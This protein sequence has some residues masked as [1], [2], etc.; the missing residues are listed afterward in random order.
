MKLP[1]EAPKQAYLCLR[2]GWLLL[3]LE[4]DKLDG[5]EVDGQ[6]CI[7]DRGGQITLIP[8]LCAKQFVQTGQ[9]ANVE[10]IETDVSTD[11]HRPHQHPLKISRYGIAI[12]VR[13]VRY[14]A[15]MYASTRDVENIFS[16]SFRLAPRSPLAS[17][18]PHRSS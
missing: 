9:Q 2:C 7:V 3:A 4:S 14:M 13:S 10:D 1:N 18:L 12:P 15:L 8:P 16:P 11:C 5:V 17:T 6:Q